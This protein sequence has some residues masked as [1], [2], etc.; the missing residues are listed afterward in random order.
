MTWE[1]FES[2]RDINGAG[3]RV[4]REPPVWL[5]YD[6]CHSRAR[7]RNAAKYKSLGWF[8]SMLMV[9][10]KLILLN[11]DAVICLHNKTEKYLFSSLI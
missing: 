1:H 10:Q 8:E 2:H 9:L 4:V 3:N 5:V 11:V 7:E 6:G